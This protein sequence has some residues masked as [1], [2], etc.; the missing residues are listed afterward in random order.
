MHAWLAELLTR[1]AE[2][3]LL[4][5]VVAALSTFILED[6][7]TI[8]C[9]LLVAEGRM[10]F[11]TAMIG[12]S[13]GIAVGD[14]GLF[15]IGR[16]LGPRVLA[17]GLVSERRLARGEEWFRRNL[18]LAVILSRFIPGMRLPTYTA[19]GLLRASLA[20]FLTVAVVASVVWTF[21]LLRLTVE[22]G[23]RLLPLLGTYRWPV[24]AAGIVLLVVL[25]RRA[26]GSINGAA[27]H[28][29]ANG[30][31]LSAFEL[32]PPWLFYIPVGIYYAWLALRHGGLLLPTVA[33]PSIYSGGLIGESK[34]EILGL[35]PE[36]Q[37]R[38]VAPYTS[39]LRRGDA[40][41][42]ELL[43]E[44]TDALDQAGLELPVA[45]KP[46][47]GQRGAG[48]CPIYEEHE[49]QRYLESFPGG[50][51]VILQ[52]LIAAPPPSPEELE[53]HPELGSLASAREAGVLY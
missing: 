52:R 30:R 12:V 14:L 31:V 36:E 2:S 32:W 28:R 7:T 22:I 4:Q 19:A 1:L 49:L 29:P 38:W 9:G 43:G 39:V 40:S 20:R 16:L 53:K 21:L 25:Q 50:N 17:W 48:V 33:N 35:V 45:A 11:I 27:G 41:G 26:V 23:E 6:P 3:P 42:R 51:R 44:A 46:D 24:A 18:V 10:A 34:L 13:T 47:I 37:S 8:G 5:G 15:G